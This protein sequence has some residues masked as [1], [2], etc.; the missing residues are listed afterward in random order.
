MA[1]PRRAAPRRAAAQMSKSHDHQVEAEWIRARQETDPT[2]RREL[3]G[4]DDWSDHRPART[5]ENR[6]IEEYGWS[7]FG[8]WHLA[9]H[10][11]IAEHN[12][13][14]YKRPYGEFKNSTVARCSPPSRVPASTSTPR[15]SS[16]PGICAACWMN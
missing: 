15:S 2:R 3:D 12:K 16:Q 8:K 13:S 14:R 6:S 4:R 11:E 10:D 5:A 7:E 1:S 9:E